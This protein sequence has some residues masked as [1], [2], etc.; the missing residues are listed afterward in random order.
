M[1]KSDGAF[2]AT[3]FGVES[4]TKE[5]LVRLGYKDLKVENGRIFVQG[6]I[7]D[8]PRLNINLRTANRVFAILKKFKAET[9]DELLVAFMILS[10][11]KFFPRMLISL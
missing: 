3:A 8:I 1:S 11:K 4:V 6:D 10:G 7:E 9:F 2:I 5:E